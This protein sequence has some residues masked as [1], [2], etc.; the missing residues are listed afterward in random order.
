MTISIRLKK[1]QPL[2]LESWTLIKIKLAHEILNFYNIYFDPL[3][4]ELWSEAPIEALGGQ[5]LREFTPKD[6][7]LVKD[8]LKDMLLDYIRK[9]LSLLESMIVMIRGVWKVNGLKVPGY[10]CVNN[11]VLSVRTYGDIEI[12]AYTYKEITDITDLF[13]TNPSETK[14][15][16]NEFISR[17]SKIRDE[18]YSIA[19]I[20]FGSGA[21][22]VQPITEWSA[23]YH[24]QP[25]DFLYKVLSGM[26]KEPQLGV[27]SH[28]RLIYKKG[29][30]QELYKIE[31]FKKH[32]LKI[33]EK[34]NVK[35]DVH[36]SLALVGKYQDSYRK[37]I[38]ELMN[39]LG[40]VLKGS[41]PEDQ[42]ITKRLTEEIN[43]AIRYM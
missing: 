10:V 29:I 11:E 34:N 9:D 37:M 17:F 38:I 2:R 21:P 6:K 14:N 20:V 4:I 35:A 27:Y 15:L 41:L 33:A 3:R 1:N 32:F 23:S 8:M 43:K 36:S 25:T 40:P 7:S 18:T 22:L 42:A 31:N 19:Y 12:G 24:M 16:V 26:G 39:F 28:L 5:L 30:A 13:W